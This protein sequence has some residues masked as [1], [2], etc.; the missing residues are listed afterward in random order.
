MIL[1]DD[2]K[3]DN[4]ESLPEVGACYGN[5]MRKLGHYFF[6]SRGNFRSKTARI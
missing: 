2:T 6:I 5:D 4:N 3:Q 1:Q